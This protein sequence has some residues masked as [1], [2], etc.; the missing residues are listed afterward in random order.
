[1]PPLDSAAAVLTGEGQAT[2]KPPAPRTSPPP[3]VPLS[4]RFQRPRGATDPSAEPPPVLDPDD[5]LRRE[6]WIR[7]VGP[8]AAGAMATL[9]VEPRAAIPE[10]RLRWRYPDL[11]DALADPG[12]Q[13]DLRATMA[14]PDRLAAANAAIAL[15]RQGDASAEEPL[16]A[17]VRDRQ[18]KL[19]SRCA[20]AEALGG[21]PPGRPGQADGPGEP[22]RTLVDQYGQFGPE[23]RARYAP[24]LHAELL[25]SL[26]RH[27]DP[28]DDQRFLAA[29]RS[30]SPEVQVAALRAWAAGRRGDL[31]TEAADLRTARDARVRA[32]ALETLA[33]RGH[34]QA[35]EWLAA[36]LSDW[37]VPVR[38]AAIAGLGHLGDP[39]SRE[40]LERLA[41]DRAEL[42]RAAAVTALA[43]AGDREA[44][45]KAAED[46]SWRVRLAVAQSLG[47]YPDRSGAAIARQ[48]LG[49]TCTSVA[50]AVLE[51]IR[52]WPL[53]QAGPVLL[54]AM[55]R[56][57]FLA[58]EQGAA[59]LAQRWPAAAAFAP[60]APPERRAETLDRLTRDFRNQFGLVDQAALTAAAGAG[61]RSSGPSPE[62]L[63]EAERHLAVLAAPGGADNAARQ[64][65][66]AGLRALG[67]DLVPALESVVRGR[68]R[69]LPEAVYRDLLPETDRA[70]A[71]LDR[72]SSHDASLR[73]RAATELATLS[74]ERPLGWL[75]T[76]RLAT[77]VATES[78]PLVWRSV[79]MAVAADGD[80]PAMRIA[81][82]GLGHESAEV[83]RRACEHF[84]AHPNPAH[85][86]LVLPALADPSDAVVLAAVKA[87]SAGGRLDDAR[88]LE[89]LL[90]HDNQSVRL[91]AAVALARMGRPS[92]VDALERLARSG[93]PVVRREVAV[94]MG[95]LG[96]PA[97]T[98]TLVHMLDDGYGVRRVALESL[99][100]V[101]GRDVAASPGASPSIAERV[102]AWK[103]W[104][105]RRGESASAG[106][107]S[108]GVV[109][110]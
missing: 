1:M 82:A 71:A 57:G 13:R 4:R 17:A 98:D 62:I 72:F 59:Q 10:D 38:V 81:G 97:F 28:A 44:V 50:P 58:R 74:P 12:P 73:R 69:P 49:D 22:L 85:A 39:K 30:P 94:A 19:S 7:A 21:L 61:P 92:G 16:V 43:R 11:E 33:L 42:I 25:R 102:D 90:G 63:A 14:G 95:D 109:Q 64:E 91:E 110:E 15:G 36:A 88:P 35:Q 75:A 9:A 84:A 66:L 105:E 99:S 27:E 67:A 100:K 101:V 24:E 86:R 80:E 32:A 83:R 60:D 106:L 45:F 37:E 31:P 8:T 76:D 54:D 89:R 34:P 51:A 47:Q 2:P 26:A 70:F 29:L 79:L 78:D 41:H 103:R 96:D 108:Q 65:A 48:L 55:G 3:A 56:R 5:L 20:A 104:H 18:L 107:R 53:E 40:A 93:D 46:K 23:A 87:V 52:A 68:K 6:G 77:L